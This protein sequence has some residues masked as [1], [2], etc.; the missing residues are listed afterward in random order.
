MTEHSVKNMLLRENK[1][2]ISLLACLW[3]TLLPSVAATH[4]LSGRPG[5]QCAEPQWS[6]K[7]SPEERQRESTAARPG[8]LP[9][10]AEQQRAIRR[11][12]NKLHSLIPVLI[13]GLIRATTCSLFTPLLLSHSDTAVKPNE[14]E[15]HAALPMMWRLT[16]NKTKKKQCDKQKSTELDNRL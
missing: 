10:S 11:P 6:V 16:S 3:V 12:P 14:A 13:R 9:P 8:G 5:S 7:T 1:A 4:L 2:T 15:F